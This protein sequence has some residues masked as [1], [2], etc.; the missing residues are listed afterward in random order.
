MG[1]PVIIGIWA[2]KFIVASGAHRFVQLIDVTLAAIDVIEHAQQ[3]RIIV[4]RSTSH[5][6]S[7]LAVWSVGGYL[8]KVL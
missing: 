6:I 5:G 8:S 4:S 7:V 1:L 3:L 2:R